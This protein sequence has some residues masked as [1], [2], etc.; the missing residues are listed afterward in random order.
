MRK[1]LKLKNKT[2]SKGK[3]GLVNKNY[4]KL[5]MFGSILVLAL[6]IASDINQQ[7]NLDV[8]NEKQSLK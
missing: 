1:N 5:L 6:I 2:E 8:N 3:N 7:N 4:L